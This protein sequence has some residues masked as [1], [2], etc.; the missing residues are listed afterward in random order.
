[1]HFLVLG[2]DGLD[3]GAIERRLSVRDNHLQG[4]RQFLDDGRWLYALAILDENEEIIG[5]MIVCDFPSREELDRQWLD[6]EPY[7]ANK[8]WERVEV[9][10][11]LIP[12][13]V[14]GQ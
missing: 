9:S 12:P 10:R 13:F 1:M 8:V 3:E 2:Y 11:A 4:A 5:S 6:R 14:L 7:I